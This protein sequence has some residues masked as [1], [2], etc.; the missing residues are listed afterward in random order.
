MAR[1]K[2]KKPKKTRGTTKKRKATAKQ[3]RN[4]LSKSGA[5]KIAKK[6]VPAGETQNQQQD[7]EREDRDENNPDVADDRF[8]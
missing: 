7:N 4:K 6:R 2:Q 1:A 3:R 8:R 5:R